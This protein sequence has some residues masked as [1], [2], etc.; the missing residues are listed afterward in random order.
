MNR[1]KIQSQPL[2]E[3]II[4]L[5]EGGRLPEQNYRTCDGL[6]SL[7]RKTDPE[8]FN[9]ACQEALSCES[10]SYKFILRVI[11]N[12][13]INPPEENKTKPLPNHQNIRG[14]N[15]YNQL[16]IKF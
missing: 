5:F 3:I 10:Y 1:A 11:E 7:R 9:K 13:K 4:K 15:Y 8:I 14:K 12:F 6:F 2:Y 16:T